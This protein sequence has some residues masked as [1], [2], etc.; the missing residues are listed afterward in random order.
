MREGMWLVVSAGFPARPKIDRRCGLPAAQY[1]REPVVIRRVK[2]TMLCLPGKQYQD[3]V[4]RSPYYYCLSPGGGAD[5][6]FSQNHPDTGTSPEGRSIG[7]VRDQSAPTVIRIHLS[8]CIIGRGKPA[9]TLATP[10]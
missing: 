6:E 8:I 5:Y 4:A 1:R 10:V 3:L 9:P 2:E 7:G